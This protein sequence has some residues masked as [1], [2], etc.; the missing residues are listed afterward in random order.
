MNKSSFKV[1]DLLIR[2]VIVGFIIAWCFML[3]RP[4]IILLLWATIL[5]VAF[6]PIF[7]WLKNL[8]GGRKKL[9]GAL[10]GLFG[11]AVILGPSLSWD[12]H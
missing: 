1:I 10:I 2:I 4:F 11:I 12:K 8:L 6:Y 7:E 3:V 9:A 5:A